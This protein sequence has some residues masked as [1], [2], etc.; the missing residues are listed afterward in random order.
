MPLIT[1]GIVIWSGSTLDVPEG[2]QI[3]D[4]TNGTP[5]LRNRFVVGVG[6][7][8]E[9]TNTGGS[10]DAIVPEHSHT[11]SIGSQGNHSHTIFVTRTQTT[12]GSFV[13]YLAGSGGVQWDTETAGNTHS[14][15]LTLNSVGE[16]GTNK[17]LPPYFALCYIQQIS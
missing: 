7:L 5:D 17:N 1:G 3:C 10:A 8:Y 2:W 16:D 15:T 14:H 4:G 11:S 13:D 9:V 6:D 12:S